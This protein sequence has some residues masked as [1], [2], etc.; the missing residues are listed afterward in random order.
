MRSEEKW[1]TSQ[2]QKSRIGYHHDKN[3][4]LQLKNT[5]ENKQVLI[6]SDIMW[7]CIGGDRVMNEI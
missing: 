2:Q 4:T 6:V 1:H 3:K 5:K 7:C